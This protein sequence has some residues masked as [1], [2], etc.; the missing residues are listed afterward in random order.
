MEG[1]FPQNSHSGASEGF[2]EV[3]ESDNLVDEGIKKLKWL[4]E[5]GVNPSN[6][7]FLVA[8]TRWGGCAGG[9]L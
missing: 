7:T 5:A 6:V 9:V 4:L 1:Y 8:K 2:V 3:V